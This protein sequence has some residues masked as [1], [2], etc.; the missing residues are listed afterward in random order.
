MHT[1]MN[2][3]TAANMTYQIIILQKNIAKYSFVP[4]GWEETGKIKSEKAVQCTGLNWT[5]SRNVNPR[6]T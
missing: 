6:D 4:S 1:G 2:E 5:A 3:Y